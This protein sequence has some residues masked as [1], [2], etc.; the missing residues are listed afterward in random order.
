V[1]A[2]DIPHRLLE[3]TVQ[4]WYGRMDLEQGRDASARARLEASIAAFTA[5]KMPLHLERAT[6]ALAEAQ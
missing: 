1:Q 3:P 5:L 6:R 4:Y 2:R